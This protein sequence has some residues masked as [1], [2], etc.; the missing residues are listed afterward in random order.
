[1]S[2]IK[3]ILIVLTGM[4]FWRFALALMTPLRTFYILSDNKF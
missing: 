1:M 3:I 2:N 4:R